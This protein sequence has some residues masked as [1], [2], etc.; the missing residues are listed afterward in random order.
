MMPPYEVVCTRPGCRRP[1]LYKIAARWSDGTTEELKTYGLTCAECLAEW[2][3]RSREKQA[4]CRG[5]QISRHANRYSFAELRAG[6]I[7]HD[8]RPI[9]QVTDCLMRLAAFFD[10]CEFDLL[11][12]RYRRP[13][14]LG[15]VIQI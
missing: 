3:G 1:A 9:G 5:L 10:Q 2:Y 6:M 4:A 12:G 14:G 7:Y 11:V 13:D 8:H 15:E